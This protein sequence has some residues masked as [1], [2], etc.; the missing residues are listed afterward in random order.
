[1]NHF[2][3]LATAADMTRTFRANREAILEPSY[4]GLN[5]LPICETFDRDAFDQLL[6]QEGCDGVRIYYGMDDGMQVHAVIV[7]VDA[8]GADMVSGGAGVS[9]VAEGDVI[10][11]NGGRCPDIC[12]GGSPLNT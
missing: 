12:P 3:S 1:M 2:I 9:L 11:E 7:G 5:L 8:A 10:I 6:L 4:Q